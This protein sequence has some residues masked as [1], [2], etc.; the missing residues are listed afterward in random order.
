MSNLQLNGIWVEKFRPKTINDIVLSTEIKDLIKNYCSSKEIPNLLFVGR[1]GIGKT[2][3]A[4]II[5]NDL[6]KCQYLYIN[7]SDENGID[8]IRTKVIG[9][10]QTKSLDG[11]I[12]VVILD[13]ADGLTSEGQKALRNVMEEYSKYTRFILT[14][15][16]EHKIIPAI[17]SRCQTIKPEPDLKETILRCSDILKQEGIS[18]SG[19]TG[20]VIT[21]IKSSFPDLRKII[22]NLQRC[23]ASGT[24]VIKDALNNTEFL[25]SIINMLNKTTKVET[26]REFLIDNE[27]KFSSDYP[28]L[29]K[30]LLNQI[31]VSPIAD[32]KKREMI[33]IIAE[34]LYRSAFV[35][36]QEINAFHCIISLANV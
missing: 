12:K 15:N 7:A 32:N 19:Q 36:D 28:G 3:L 20:K 13:E 25:D 18:T 31:F 5:C 10:S 17:Q 9:F 33:T 4:K 26:L 16:Y 23:S 35:M 21:L 6:L 29:L 1:A 8:T 24:L 11:G 2:S 22:N 34:H 27:S 14:A 30:S